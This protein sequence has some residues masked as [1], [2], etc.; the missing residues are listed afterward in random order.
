MHYLAQFLDIR[1][2]DIL[3]TPTFNRIPIKPNTSFKLEKP[4]IM[5]SSLERY[6]TLS[7]DELAVIEKKTRVVY[8]DALKVVAKIP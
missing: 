2:D 7:P 5:S 4:G 6:K 8:E 1:F 3:L